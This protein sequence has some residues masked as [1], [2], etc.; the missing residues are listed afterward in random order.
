MVTSPPQLNPESLVARIIAELQANP[1]AQA[2]LLHTLLTNEFL[3]VPL[4]LERI[5]A[6]IAEM[7][8]AWT[9]LKPT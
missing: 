7:R 5:E 6:D 1:D 4:R 8:A 9:S 2:L 3:G